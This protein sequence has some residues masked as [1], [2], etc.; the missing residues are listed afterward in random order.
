VTH[1]PPPK[2]GETFD[3]KKMKEALRLH[4]DLLL[5]EMPPVIMERK[6]EVL[7]V[8]LGL[9][10]QDTIKNMKKRG[11]LA[12]LLDLQ[13]DKLNLMHEYGTYSEEMVAR[14]DAKMRA[15]KVKLSSSASAASKPR[16]HS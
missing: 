9:N 3:L 7:D 4:F 12:R 15:L 16:P 10:N 8:N 1:L 14:E 6:C 11:A 5:D 13:T 2:K